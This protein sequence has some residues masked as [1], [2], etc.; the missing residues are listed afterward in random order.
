MADI[1]KLIYKKNTL[2][3]GWSE[4]SNVKAF[5]LPWTWSSASV[6]AVAQDILD[7]YNA[8][9]IPIV[10]FSNRTYN[11]SYYWTADSD[12]WFVMADDA[13]KDFSTNR[14]TIAAT[15]WTATEVSTSSTALSSVFLSKTNTTSY[16]PS[17]NYNPA[18]KKYVD[19]MVWDIETLLSNI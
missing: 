15:N 9:N 16:T 10:K 13:Y 8:G 19:D 5:T 17:G 2:Y 11:L 3:A 4:P 18:T 12:L 1:A 7:W 6:L 14:I